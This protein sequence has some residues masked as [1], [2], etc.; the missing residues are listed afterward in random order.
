MD[1]TIRYSV[2]SPVITN[3]IKTLLVIKNEKTLP[4]NKK[5]KTKHIGLK[6]NHFSFIYCVIISQKI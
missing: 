1:T 6:L 5:A 2:T 4:N 3:V